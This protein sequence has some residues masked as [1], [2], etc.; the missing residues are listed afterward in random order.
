M[1]KTA[2]TSYIPLLGVPDPRS[3]EKIMLEDGV[4]L[5]TARRR[6]RF[7]PA[8][9]RGRK[10]TLDYETMDKLLEAILERRGELSRRWAEE[11]AEIVRCDRRT[12][13]ARM[14]ELKAGRGVV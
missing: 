13:Y 8:G 9:R 4:S 10:R 6:R 3:A 1:T 7:G 2:N 14:A 11:I 12:V 5:R